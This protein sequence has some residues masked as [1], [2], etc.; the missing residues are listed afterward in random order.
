MVLH[1]GEPGA[2]VRALLPDNEGL[3][4]A[5]RQGQGLFPDKERQRPE[6]LGNRLRRMGGKASGLSRV[7]HDPGPC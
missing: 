3:Q 5:P 2:A 1:T 7:G 4:Y 6:R